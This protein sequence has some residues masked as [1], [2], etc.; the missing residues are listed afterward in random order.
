M[1]AFDMTIKSSLLLLVSFMLFNSYV[2]ADQRTNNK[3]VDIK[4][5]CHAY[6]NFKA[7]KLRSSEIVD[8]CQQFK[9]KALLLVNT[10]SKCGFTPQFKGLEILYKKYGSKLAIVGFPS[11]DFSQEH[12]DSG[13]V[14]E[15]CYVN[16][17]VTFT[18]L[19][20]SIVKGENANLLF[21][22]FF[23]KYDRNYPVY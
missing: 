19:E 13:K 7:I 22:M 6:L 10:A 17:G 1:K 5:P 4:Q 20:K 18:M 2:Y 15:V 21:K 16:Y 8:F 11:N 12:D 3:A 9:G 23:K 14:A